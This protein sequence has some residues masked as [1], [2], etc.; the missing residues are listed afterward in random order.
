MEGELVESRI[1]YGR[2]RSWLLTLKDGGGYLTLRFFH[3]SRRQFQSLKAG[4]HV[5]CFGEAR[6][7]PRHWRWPIPNTVYSRP[8]RLRWK[9]G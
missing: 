1:A 3:F 2:R 7:G 4:Q 8:R 6:F 5:R 9:A